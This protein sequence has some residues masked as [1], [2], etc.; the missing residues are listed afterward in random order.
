[1]KIVG[2]INVNVISAE[3]VNQSEGEK[4]KKIRRMR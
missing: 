1:M 3:V 4:R 2:Q